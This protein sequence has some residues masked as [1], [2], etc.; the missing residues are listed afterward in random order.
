MHSQQL[1]GFE[2]DFLSH[3][4]QLKKYFVTY[5]SLYLITIFV[6]EDMP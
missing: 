3:D 2:N 1:N 5:K 4:V 6:I